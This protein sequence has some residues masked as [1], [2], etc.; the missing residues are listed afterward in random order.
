M[1]DSMPN[2]TEFVT[3]KT[4][5][6]TVPDPATS[7]NTKTIDSD[8]L[9]LRGLD[10]SRDAVLAFT[11]I[12]SGTVKLTMKFNSGMQFI[13]SDFNSPDTGSPGPQV[14]QGIISGN[15]LK[16]QGNQLKITADGSGHVELS[17]FVLSYHVTTT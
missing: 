2:F 1:G 4:S 17:D 6:F 10:R 16:R 11:L 15:D 9:P 7:T 3:F 13:S 12:A 8:I 14:L 5:S